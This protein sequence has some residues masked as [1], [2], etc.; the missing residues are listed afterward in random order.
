MRW[1]TSGLAIALLTFG[2]GHVAYAGCGSQPGDQ[3]AVIAARTAADAACNCQ[4][5]TS[6]GAYVSCV[7]GVANTLSSGTNPSL[8][9]DCKGAVKRCAAHSSCG[10]PGFVTCCFQSA[11]GP[12]C[13]VVNANSNSCA[14]RGGTATLDPMNT[15]CCSNTAPLAENAC[16]ASPSGAFVN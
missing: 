6:H 12:K 13:K 1:V 2:I 14:A 11:K 10:K 4:S 8:P 3:D 15:S 9:T 16:M 7:A 5:F